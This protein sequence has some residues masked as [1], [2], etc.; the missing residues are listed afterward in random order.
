MILS[1]PLNSQRQPG[2]RTVELKCPPSQA[3]TKVSRKKRGRGTNMG[4]EGY[5]EPETRL[6]EAATLQL[7]TPD[8][9]REDSLGMARSSNLSR[10]ARN[11]EPW[12]KSLY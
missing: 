2:L 9:L 4:E 1:T 8:N 3:D 11:P 6:E 10:E 7:Q 12:D 5:A